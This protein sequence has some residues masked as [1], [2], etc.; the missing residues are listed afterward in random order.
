MSEPRDSTTGP[1]AGLGQEIRAELEATREA[2]H[3]L[4]SALTDEDWPRPSG[5][6]AWT[7][8]QL[9]YHMT[10]APRM[11]PT[12]VRIIRRGGRAPRVPAFLFNGLNVLMTRWGARK[13]TR[14][15][16]GQAYDEAHAAT[17]AV[18]ETIQD[19]EWARGVEYPDWDPMLSGFVT[20]ERLFRYLPLH[21]EAH[22]GQVRQ[23]LG[24]DPPAA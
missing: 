8:G 6:E 18:L 22:A 4:L 17:L 2:Y 11:L 9:M 15:T 14:L 3:T 20:I 23:G 12:D 24:L 7:V 10:I 21:F 1:V 19:D 13:W 5:N 16:V